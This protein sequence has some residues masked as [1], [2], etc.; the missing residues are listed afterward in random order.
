MCLLLLGMRVFAMMA[1]WLHGVAC[2]H[3]DSF[4]HSVASFLHSFVLHGVSF[5]LEL[6]CNCCLLYVC[7]SWLNTAANNAITGTGLV[8]KS[9]VCTH[10]SESDFTHGC[11][12]FTNSCCAVVVITLS[13]PLHKGLAPCLRKAKAHQNHGHFLC[14]PER[15]HTPVHS[16]SILSHTCSLIFNTI[17]QRQQSHA[18]SSQVTSTPYC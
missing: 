5:F 17:T 3:A 10:G 8:T 12:I 11:L 16:F 7:G 1:G 13:W 14:P 2:L 15:L 9:L 4:L 18:T 6:S